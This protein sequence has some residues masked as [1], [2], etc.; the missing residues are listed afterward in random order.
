MDSQV[1]V[2]NAEES[3]HF[4]HQPQTSHFTA[5]STVDIS[6]SALASAVSGIG[7]GLSP[8]L[9]LC[10]MYDPPQHI[11]PACLS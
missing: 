4:V 10:Q 5:R 9:N 3:I 7:N 8:L 1:T 2:E 11:D 6:I